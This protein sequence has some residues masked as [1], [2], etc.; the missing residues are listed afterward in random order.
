MKALKALK[1]LGLGELLSVRSRD[2][3]SVSCRLLGGSWYFV[4]K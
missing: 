1:A 4:T 2:S 3:A